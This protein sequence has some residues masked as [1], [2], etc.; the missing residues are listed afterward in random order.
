MISGCFSTS[1]SFVNFSAVCCFDRLDFVVQHFVIAGGT[2]SSATT[3][4]QGM[5]D[6]LAR[7]EKKACFVQMIG[8]RIHTGP[9]ICLALKNASRYEATSMLSSCSKM[10]QT[11]VAKN[12]AAFSKVANPGRTG[13]CKRCKAGLGLHARQSNRGQHDPLQYTD[14]S[15]PGRRF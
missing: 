3:C 10:L 4:R 13:A 1:V 15:V 2:A 8:R 7:S 9:P 12:M 6:K 14:T 5:L 11:Y